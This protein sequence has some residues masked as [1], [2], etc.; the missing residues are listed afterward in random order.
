MREN[1]EAG[2]KGGHEEGAPGYGRPWGQ[3]LDSRYLGDRRCMI[4]LCYTV[5]G[6][7]TA[8]RRR[9]VPGCSIESECEMIHGAL[10]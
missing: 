8:F 10:R 5:I 4:C 9:S 3:V 7:A 6:G 2:I 1:V